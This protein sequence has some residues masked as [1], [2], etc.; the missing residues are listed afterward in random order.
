M[1]DK[2]I[3]GDGDETNN[4]HWLYKCSIYMAPHSQWW[5]AL[6]VSRRYLSKIWEEEEEEDLL[7]LHRDMFV[8]SLSA[9]LTLRC[10]YTTGYQ[11]LNWNKKVWNDQ[12]SCG[13]RHETQVTVHLNHLW[14]F[15][16][17]RWSRRSVRHVGLLSGCSQ[18]FI[19]FSL[20]IIFYLFVSQ[21]C[22]WTVNKRKY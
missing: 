9:F 1:G 17:W 11:L 2:E 15:S 4:F 22:R 13:I 10:V 3:T 5:C 19:C 12:L 20:M 7:L 21:H 8:Y 16:D 18:Q 6:Q 14:L